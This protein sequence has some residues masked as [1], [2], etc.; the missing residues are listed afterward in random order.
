MSMNPVCLCCQGFS[1]K[2]C[3]N[4]YFIFF[5]IYLFIFRALQKYISL[6]TT[7]HSVRVYP[8]EMYLV[9]Y[10]AAEAW[11]KKI[12]TWNTLLSPHPPHGKF[13]LLERTITEYITYCRVRLGTS[14]PSQCTVFLTL[15]PGSRKISH[16]Y[17]MAH[18]SSLWR[19]VLITALG[20]ENF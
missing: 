19:T 2:C 15:L 10:S 12:C 11:R 17:K 14:L 3:L 5:Y 16:F 13:K 20:P 8:I 9:G 6:R 18:F 4:I 1:V 7:S